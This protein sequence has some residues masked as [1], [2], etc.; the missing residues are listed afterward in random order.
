MTNTELRK[1]SIAIT[2]M[3]VRYILA[4]CR[5]SAHELRVSREGVPRAAED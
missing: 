4:N 2:A 1:A 3:T 5:V